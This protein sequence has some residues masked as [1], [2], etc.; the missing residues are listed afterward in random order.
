MLQ[1]I[2]SFPPKFVSCCCCFSFLLLPS[3]PFFGS[4]KVVR[5]SVRVSFLY[6]S[7]RPS[8]RVA[9]VD[10]LLFS[11]LK[12]I[13]ARVHFWI[14][15][16]LQKGNNREGDRSERTGISTVWQNSSTQGSATVWSRGC[17]KRA[18]MVTGGQD[19]GITKPRDNPLPIQ[20]LE[21]LPW[22]EYA[23]LVICKL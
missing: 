3:I 14:L 1:S 17:V 12:V 13:N 16:P 9:R 18:P 8:V 21:M 5:P 2:L 11:P 23:F 20:C 22:L 7:C 15:A 4:S 10:L 19:T 6:R